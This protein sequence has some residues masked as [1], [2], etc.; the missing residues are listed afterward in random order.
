MRQ[1][2]KRRSHQIQQV[3]FFF[4]FCFYFLSFYFLRVQ[5]HRNSHYSPE[6]LQWSWLDYMCAHQPEWELPKQHQ[7][8]FHM[9]VRMM[10]NQK[11]ALHEEFIN[12]DLADNKFEWEKHFPVLCLKERVCDP[13][14]PCFKVVCSC[15]G[16][17]YTDLESGRGKREPSSKC[18]RSYA[19]CATLL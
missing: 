7:P 9:P 15:L 19:N 16:D 18:N 11:S 17:I 12:L 2:Q 10:A 3:R 13:C 14:Y 5:L 8:T 4:S 1:E 6:Q